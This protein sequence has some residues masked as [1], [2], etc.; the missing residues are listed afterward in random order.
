M[1]NIAT[2]LFTYNRSEHTQKVLDALCVNTVLP[3]KLYIFQD[4]LKIETHRTEWE[5]VNRLIHSV[6]FCPTEIVVAKENKG[7]ANSIVTGVNCVFE[8]YDAVIVLEDDC[9]PMPEFMRFMTE[10]LKHYESEERVY[11]ITGYAYPVDISDS[12]KDAY[13]CGRASSWGWGTW[14]NK[15]KIFE[16][17][18]EALND[19]MND[20]DLSTEFAIWG[21]DLESIVL[22]TKAGRVD[23]WAAFWSL[24]I[25][26]HRGVCLT[27]YISL[28]Q[29]IGFDGTGVNCGCGDEYQTHLQIERKEGFR[30]PQVEECKI[31]VKKAFIDFLGGRMALAERQDGKKDILIYGFGNYF[32]YNEA[33]IVKEYNV[34]GIVDKDKSGWYAGK[35]IISLEEINGMDYDAILVMIYDKEMCEIIKKQLHDTYKIPLEQVV[36]GREIYS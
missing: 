27:P 34:V 7:L 33:K 30:F 9:V 36:I 12:D 23:S 24:N 19:I 35:K 17:T 21:R 29:N 16:R 18:D 20:Y 14:K 6:D 22:A 5:R 8:K 31:E 13:F 25:I 32:R 15:W 1:M 11:N 28:I 2:I 10:G 4:G 26:K 3:E